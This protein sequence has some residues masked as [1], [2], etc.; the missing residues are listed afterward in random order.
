MSR[1]R[2]GVGVAGPVGGCVRAV[3]THAD[4]WVG[5]EAFLLTP[6][7]VGDDRR[8][9]RHRGAERC[10]AGVV[11]VVELRR[12][13]LLGAVVAE[14]D[15]VVGR[16][17]TLTGGHGR[18]HRS[19]PIVARTHSEH[20]AGAALWH[21]AMRADPNPRALAGR[22]GRRR[23]HTPPGRRR[24][25]APACSTPSSRAS[26][27]RATTRPA[28]TRSPAARASPGAPSS[29]S[30]ARG[31]S[32]CSRSSTGGGTTSSTPWRPP[33]SKATP[34]SSACTP[35]S[36]CSPSTTADPHLAHLQIALDL[37]HDPNV[38]SERRGAAPRFRAGE[39]MASTVRAGARRGRDRP[40]A[41]V[42]RA[43]VLRGFLSANVIATAISGSEPVVRSAICSFAGSPARSA[44]VPQSRA[45]LSTDRPR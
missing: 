40:R 45:C 43:F 42:V 36:M 26:S 11:G 25:P 33:W 3:A 10:D 9:A 23:H 35:C 1:R 32:S 37:T 18:R 27:R 7:L 41:R 39:G 4:R 30:S 44:S 28:R 8:G 22:R 29:T 16:D 6:L 24:G 15:V 19:S 13:V 21:T 14:V 17:Q 20:D 34:W 2:V 12:Q 38:S 5:L 31:S